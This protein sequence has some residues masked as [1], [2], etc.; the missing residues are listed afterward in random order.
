[1]SRGSEAAA[2]SS[3]SK[4]AGILAAVRSALSGLRAGS[5]P[6]DLSISTQLL[7]PAS[8]LEMFGA[9]VGAL[10]LCAHTLCTPRRRV[11]RL[12][13]LPAAPASTRRHARS[14]RRP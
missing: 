3:P 4:H 14:T 1:M 6:Y 13:R 12:S 2:P 5:L 7:H 9:L 11:C 10:A 8:A